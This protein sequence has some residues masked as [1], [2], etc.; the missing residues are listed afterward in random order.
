VSDLSTGVSASRQGPGTD[1]H[2]PSIVF[3]ASAVASHVVPASDQPRN[4][5]VTSLGTFRRRPLLPG[6]CGAAAAE[7]A[8]DHG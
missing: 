1:T 7:R 5:T 3:D 8:R 6:R 4:V 2:I